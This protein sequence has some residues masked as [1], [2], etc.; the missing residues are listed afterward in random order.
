[1]KSHAHSSPARRRCEIATMAR[2]SHE[3]SV[4]S[5]DHFFCDEYREDYHNQR[6]QSVECAFETNAIPKYQGNSLENHKLGPEWDEPSTEEAHK[7][8]EWAGPGLEE[9]GHPMLNCDCQ[10][11]ETLQQNSRE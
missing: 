5:H 8:H 11:Q 4:K 7:L 6:H 3:L 2:T 9:L 1:M 10:L